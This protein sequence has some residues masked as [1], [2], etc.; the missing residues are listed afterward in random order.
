MKIYL[1]GPMTGYP[2]FNAPAF[3]IAAKMLR[4]QGH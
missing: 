3:R 4:E 1:A 2:E